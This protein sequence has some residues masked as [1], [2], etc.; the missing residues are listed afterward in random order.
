M[1]LV[2]RKKLLK[3]MGPTFSQLPLPP[4]F[5]PRGSLVYIFSLLPQQ[6]NRKVLP[7]LLTPSMARRPGSSASS[8]PTMSPSHMMNSGG[9]GISGKST[10][11][12][13]NAAELLAKVM[14]KRD[15]DYDYD[16]EDGGE[17]LYQ[18]HLPPLTQSRRRDDKRIGKGSVNEKKAPA[19]KPVILPP[20]KFDDESEDDE[21][22]AD[23]PRNPVIVPKKNARDPRKAPATKPVVLPP[24]KFD[25]GDEIIADLRRI[26]VDIS[27]RNARGRKEAPTVKPVVNTPKF[28]D[29]YDSDEI[30]ADVSRNPV[31]I[32][33]PVRGKVAPAV[34]PVVLPTKFDD[35]LDS[36][37]I[38]ADVPRKQVDI[39]QKNGKG[40]LRVRV[41]AYSRRNPMDEFE[42]NGE[43]KQNVQFDVPAKQSEAQLKYK[44]R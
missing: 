35:E 20:P 34:K 8:S 11:R 3:E 13:Q 22:R 36:D 4:R 33:V 38:A 1:G 42:Q 37:E 44:K 30:T 24:P 41:P 25:D 31:E 10:L 39:P 2:E 32:R 7:T 40:A 26:P 9:G 5:G 23:V 27:G 43:E 12:K 16:D 29:E 18:V 6:L 21:I 28:D 15:Y 14:E 19:K 17:D